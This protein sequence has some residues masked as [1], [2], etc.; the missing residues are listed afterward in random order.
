MKN[1]RSRF[2]F[3]LIELLVVIAIIAILAAILFPVFAKVREKARQISCLSNEKQWALGFVQY[4]MDSDDGFPLVGYEQ[5]GG[6][7]QLPATSYWFN[8]VYN[9]IPGPQGKGIWDCPDDQTNINTVDISLPTASAT[10]VGGAWSATF[11]GMSY[12]MNDNLCNGN[13]V[14]GHATYQTVT[15]SQCVSP[16]QTATLFDGAQQMGLPEIGQDVG[17][18]MTGENTG[19]DDDNANGGATGT[20]WWGTGMP[21]GAP[22]A[23]G[24]QAQSL[25]PFHDGGTNVAFVDGHAKWYRTRVGNLSLMESNLKWQTYVDPSQGTSTE[26]SDYGGGRFWW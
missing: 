13:F 9:Y 1:T 7:F 19:L 3:T 20:D 24:I 22:A 16:D 8:A 12:L 14:A 23:D 17:C 21:F 26:W 5:A 2:G 25:T 15:T 18:S 10:A 11:H 6:A 4:T